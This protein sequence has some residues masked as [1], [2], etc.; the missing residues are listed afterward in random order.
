MQ[1]EE[2]QRNGRR[3]STK[4]NHCWLRRLSLSVAVGLFSTFIAPAQP[5]ATSLTSDSLVRRQLDSF[6][7]TFTQGNSIE[8]IFSGKKKFERMFADIRQA[9]HSVHLE[10]FNF[11]NDSIASLLFDILCEK[12]RQGVEV[13]ALFDGFGNDSN[14]QPLLKHH[15][16]KLRDEGIDIYEFDPIRFPYINHI[17]PRDHRKIVVIDG[18]I[19]YTGGMN[20]ADY[21]INGTEQVG[22]WRDMHCRLQGPVV[23]QLQHIMLRM[24]Q[25]VAGEDLTQQRQYYQGR[26]VASNTPS[27]PLAIVNREPGGTVDTRGRVL[28]QCDAMRHFYLAAIDNAQDS[29]MIVNPYFTLTPALYRALKRAI[30]RGVKVRILVSAKSDVPVIPDIVGYNVHRL[31]R[32]GAEV[33]YYE[34]GFHHSKVM[35]VDGRFCTVGSANLDARGM[36]YD[37]ECNTVV[38]DRGTTLQI[39]SMFQADKQHSFRL[40]QEKWRQWRNPWQR[41]RGK[42]AY[43]LRFLL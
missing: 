39:D 40:T 4:T 18:K 5:S 15:L 22:E 43:L 10:Y 25:K 21:Y 11:R 36:R 32:H 7:I 23:N 12:R 41:F 6:G 30:R 34:P 33:W 2:T 35:T 28:G 14:N 37:Y 13:R 29:L 3:S 24:W 31:M 20:V 42:L 38:L 16:R 17:W 27:C 26:P 1:P 9:R 8:L 19:A